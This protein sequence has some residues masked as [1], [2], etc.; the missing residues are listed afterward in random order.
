MDFSAAKRR[1]GSGLVGKPPR[2]VA[3]TQERQICEFSISASVGAAASEKTLHQ[4]CK[5]KSRH[6]QTCSSTEGHIKTKLV[7]NRNPIGK[8]FEVDLAF[9]LMFAY[10]VETWVVYSVPGDLIATPFFAR[11]GRFCSMQSAQNT[12]LPAM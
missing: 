4:E 8:Y 3:H 7:S 1:F 11:R 5:R 2:N 9:A 6:C 12:D 10:D